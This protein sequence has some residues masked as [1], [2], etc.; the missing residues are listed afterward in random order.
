MVLTLG[1]LS[2]L[3]IGVAAEE[4]PARPNILFCLA[5]DWGWPHAGAYGDQT[6]QTPAFD[7]LAREGVLFHHAFVSSPSCTPCRNTLLTGQQFYRLEAGANL[8]STL[9]IRY[10][11]FMFM[12]RE[13]GYEIGHWRKA[14]GPGDFKKGGYTEHPCGPGGDFSTF[15]RNRD[16]AKPFCFW[17]GTSDPHRGYKMGSGAKSGIAIENIRV[18]GFFPDTDEVRSDMADYYFEVQRWDRDVGEAIRQLEQENELENTLI[19]M[20]GDHGMPFPRCKGNLYDSG[21][22]V[23]LAMRWGK[24]VKP[25]RRI[26]DFVSFTDLAPTFLDAAGVEAD[27]TM[28]GRSLLPLLKGGGD[29]RVDPARDFMVFGRERHVP[30]QAKPSM[31]GYPAR[32]I[33]T[34]KWL[35]ILNL[36]AGRWPAGVPAGATHRIGTFADCDDGPTKQVIMQMRDDPAGRIFYD[37]CFAKREGVELYDCETD[38]EQLRNLA[39]DPQYAGTVQELRTRL[40]EYLKATADPRFTDQPVRFED[41]PYR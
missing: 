24:Q 28:T 27:Q 19:V 7:R 3:H 29:G 30:A 33:R 36:E 10:P 13:A 6:V 21:A 16:K 23:P 8:W 20:T 12:L 18:P 9:D 25:N 32:A 1:M 41:Y 38:P 4:P 15:M 2:A 34:D 11:N 17:F 14:W 31:A 39:D 26:T 35:L 37:L 5:D 22:R 40:A